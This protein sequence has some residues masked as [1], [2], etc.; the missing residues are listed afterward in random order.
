MLNVV[1]GL[2][3]SESMSRAINVYARIHQAQWV[4][5]HYEETF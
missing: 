2:G 1:G 5:I 3:K 4:E